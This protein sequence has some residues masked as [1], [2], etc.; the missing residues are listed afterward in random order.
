MRRCEV[1]INDPSLDEFRLLPNSFG[2]TDA[3]HI[4]YKALDAALLG[5][6]H[7][8]SIEKALHAIGKFLSARILRQRFRFNCCPSDV[9]KLFAYWS[10]THVSW[11]FEFLGRFLEPL[12]PVLPYLILYYSVKKMQTST[13]YEVAADEGDTDAKKDAR[14]LIVEVGE[15]LQVLMLEPKLGFLKILALQIESDARWIRGCHCHEELWMAENVTYGTKMKTFRKQTDHRQDHPSC[16][17]KGKR[18]TEMIL[19]CAGIDDTMTC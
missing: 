3:L 16:I 8:K 6:S 17:W 15:A 14:K 18:L 4:M 7:W 2:A 10:R 11:E 19:G 13:Q 9:G 12:V 5:S 1:D